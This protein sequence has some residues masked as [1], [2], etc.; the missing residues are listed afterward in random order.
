MQGYGTAEWLG[1]L[2]IRFL[3]SAQ[4]VISWLMGLSPM[5]D[6]T[7]TAQRLLGIISLPLS[8]SLPFSSPSLSK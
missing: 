7:V 3:I 6:S 4:V 2:S 8:L 5:S 1:L